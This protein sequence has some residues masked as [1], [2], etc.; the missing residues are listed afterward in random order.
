[1]TDGN[2]RSAPEVA[3]LRTATPQMSAAD[4]QPLITSPVPR[5]VWASLLRSDPDAVVSQ[6]LAWHDAVLEAGRYRDISVLYQ[7][8]SGRQVVLPLARPRRA[9]AWSTTTGSWPGEWGVGGPISEGGRI[10]PA[11]AAAV[12]ADV[13]RRRTMVTEIRLRP[14]T[15]GD[16]LSASS[17]FAVVEHGLQWHVLDLAGGFPTVWQ[18]RFRG[19]ARTAVRKAE[20]SGLEVEVDRSGRLLPAFFSLLESSIERWADM[21]H[22]PLWMTRWRTIRFSPPAMVAA[23]ARH[24]GSDCAV[25]MARLKGEPVAAIVVLSSGAHAK[26]WKGAMNKQLAGPIRANDLLHRLAIEDACRNGYSFYE[27]GMT[28]PASPLAVFKEKLGAVPRPVHSLRA[29]RLPIEAV[30]TGS[31]GLVKKMIGFKDV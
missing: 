2:N 1:M 8:A 7:F 23:V 18:D 4:C 9:P 30:R 22:E 19:T 29:E 20:R 27:M 15:A 6:S 13:A 5:E 24:F 11:E 25:W 12:L 10:A 16:W 3:G 28:R 26:Y 21:Q 31:R 14:G 17:Q